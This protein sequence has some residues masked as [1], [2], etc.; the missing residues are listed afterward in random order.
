LFA[1]KADIAGK[2]IAQDGHIENRFLVGSADNGIIIFGGNEE[3]DS[4]I[5][6]SLY[7]S[8]PLGYGWKLSQDGTAEFNNIIARG[9]IQSSVFEYNKISSVGGSLYI[10]PTI[11]IEEK[12]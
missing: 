4:Y 6:S 7:S 2:I 10:A 11:Y 12:S 3:E 1:N 9:K 8:G 5:G